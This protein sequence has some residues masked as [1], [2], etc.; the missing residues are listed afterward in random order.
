MRAWLVLLGGLLIWAA[1]FFAVYAVASL[2]PG[3]D[4]AWY[5]TLL[6]T[7][8]ATGAAAWLWWRTRR[9]PQDDRAGDDL[10]R[11]MEGLAS[12]SCALALIAIF[13]QG[14]LT[15]LTLIVPLNDSF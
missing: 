10:G 8:V 7:V 12:M 4:T 14:A 2:F 3:T 5:L 11:W 1:H 9:V 15:L 6:L 13:Y